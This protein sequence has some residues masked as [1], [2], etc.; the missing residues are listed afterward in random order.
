MYVVLKEMM[1]VSE[2]QNADNMRYSWAKDTA[3]DLE[4]APV[5]FSQKQ[6]NSKR[7]VSSVKQIRSLMG[8][9]TLKLLYTL[10]KYILTILNESEVVGTEQ[11]FR[12][13][14]TVARPKIRHRHRM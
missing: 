11:R 5:L 4:S 12:I 1:L 7:Y 2:I 8:D 3:N 13:S 10:L 6:Q 14:F 9:M